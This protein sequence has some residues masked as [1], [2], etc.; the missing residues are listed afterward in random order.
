MLRE[1]DEDEDIPLTPE[2][3]EVLAIILQTPAKA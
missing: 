1:T 2:E 3:Q